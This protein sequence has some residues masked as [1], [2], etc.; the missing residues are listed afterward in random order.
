MKR[1]TYLLFLLLITTNGWAQDFKPGDQAKNLTEQKNVMV[2]YST[3]I[4]N[5][6]VPIC[7]LKS[8]DYALP[9]S[10]NYIAQG[11]K[12]SDVSGLIGYNWS[13]NT[14]GIVTRTMRGGFPDEDTSF[15]YLRTENNST[16]LKEDAK[17]VGL[18]KRDG[19]SDIFTAVFNGQKVDFI[20]RMDVNRRIYTEPL[21]QTDVRIECETTSGN[22]TGWTITDNNG[23][24]YI[25]RQVEKNTDVQRVDV[26]TTNA[27]SNSSY[28]SAWHITRIIPYN[29]APIEFYYKA[30]VENSAYCSKDRINTQS[31]WNSYTMNYTYGKAMKEQPFDFKK[32]QAGYEAQ[33]EEARYYLKMCSQQIL[34]KEVDAQMSVIIIHGTCFSQPLEN[35]IVQSNNRIIGTLANIKEL[36]SASENLENTLKSLADYCYMLPD[37]G[38][39]AGACLKNAANMVHNCLIEIKN[40]TTKEISGGTRYDVV[41][42]LLSTIISPEH[43]VRFTYE[44]I[45]NQCL[46]KISIYQR[47]EVL[48][49]SVQL[50]QYDKD[51][52][53]VSFSDKNGKEISNFKFDY[54]TF[55]DFPEIQNGVKSDL[56]DYC[57]ARDASGKEYEMLT[58]MHSLKRITLTDGGKIGIEYEKN[59][60]NASANYGGIRLKSLIFNDEAS[61]RNDTISYGYPAPGISVYYS[62]SNNVDVCYS[63]FCDRITYDRVRPEGHPLIN[64]GNNGLYYPYV[65]ETMHGKG[66][67]TYRYQIASPSTNTIYPFWINGLLSEKAVYD[68]NGNLQQM[69]K[70]NYE[71]LSAYS[72]QLPQ[73][74]PSDYYLDGESLKS[75]YKS[76]TTN[77]IK[78]DELYQNNIEPRLSPIN[79]S[80]FYYLP[81]GGKIVLKEE[82]E[83]KFDEKTPY[84]QTN[85]QYDNPK[86]MFPTSISYTGSDG[87][88]LT[89]VCKRVTDIAD[90]VDPVIDKMKQSNL[91][92]P[93]VKKLTIC[94]G[95]LINETVLR[96]QANEQSGKSF[97]APTE[98][99]MYIPTTPTTYSSTTK[100]T[101][102]FTY[103]ESNYAL[104]ATYQYASNKTSKLPVKKSE[105]TAKMSYAYDDYGK[106]IME[107]NAIGATADDCYKNEGSGTIV[108]PDLI[109][110]LSNFKG[111]YGYSKQILATIPSN[112]KDGQF[113]YFFNSREHN[114]IISFGE[115]MIKSNTDLNKAQNYYDI[116]SLDEKKIFRQFK[117]EYTRLIQLYP[118]YEPLR[119]FID[120]LENLISYDG[121]KLFEYLFLDKYSVESPLNYT[122]FIKM[123]SLPD[124][125]KLKLYVLKG[126]D[127]ASGYITHAGGET[128]YTVESNN[129]SLLKVYD[130]DLSS[131]TGVTSVTANPQGMYMALVPE[132][133]SFK[134]T[135]YNADGTVYAQFDQSSNVELYTYDAAGKVIQTKDQ[136]GNVLKEY[137]YNRIIKQ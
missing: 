118:K 100:E 107:C 13:L 87:H 67:N 114:F 102:L 68:T 9:I 61:N 136:Y 76:Q 15:G 91:F 137:T 83:Y 17:T 25:Y 127:S 33:I 122:Y 51:L 80:K 74:Q 53:K 23:N 38:I 79:A 19:E 29:G 89:K 78:G 120:T 30:D 14:G 8:G 11:V 45:T 84:S 66:M 20:I 32:Y 88:V 26:S 41:S 50:T 40:I 128:K 73:I 4:F 39:R 27:L 94:D 77:Y 86:S 57:S 129:S 10:L 16:P 81:Y 103:G 117:Q 47:N 97:I 12:G 42:P 43:I 49:S 132:G 72:N 58:A 98:A 111:A 60:A 125:K 5:Y 21:E 110:S 55:S 44:N 113:L 109:M 48:L 95:Q 90:G 70:Y 62:N 7:N 35:I 130:I 92:S 75:H 71:T 108:K 82:V 69:T 126:S 56:W 6:T 135:S 101:K 115:E 133:A 65:T 121:Q 123:T 105:R 18:R 54:Y 31:V 104:V 96:Y 3:G 99:L 119:R 131:Y 85:Y 36:T 124:S 63:G 28:N 106:L 2:D 64:M 22:I 116:I 134:A 46:N 37:P 52:K 59:K 93:I 24:R 1:I 112:I 34:L